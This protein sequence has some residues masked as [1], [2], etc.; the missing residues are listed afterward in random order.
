MHADTQAQTCKVVNF[1]S[2]RPEWSKYFVQF[3]KRNK[4][5]Q[6]SSHF[7]SQSVPDFPDKFRPECSDFI[8]HVPFQT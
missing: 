8:L 6:F 5:E 4:T 2:F 3:K 7:K 1:V